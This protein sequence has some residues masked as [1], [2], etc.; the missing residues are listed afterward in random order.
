MVAFRGA[1]QHMVKEATL[2]LMLSGVWGWREICGRLLGL[3]DWCGRAAAVIG[4]WKL[5]DTAASKERGNG[6]GQHQ[7]PA[8]ASAVAT[9][10]NACVL[11]PT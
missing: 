9:D 4:A 6:Q 8:T 3:L 10:V 5:N 7:W 2:D 1:D 11:G